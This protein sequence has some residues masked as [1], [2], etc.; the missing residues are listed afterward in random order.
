ME[1]FYQKIQG[2]SDGIDLLYRQVVAAVPKPQLRFNGETFAPLTT[3]QYHFVEV[4]SWRGRSSAFMAVE[5]INSG[6]DIRFD[7][8]DTWQGTSNETAHTED[9]AVIQG[10][11]YEEFI[12]AMK[13]VE[14]HYH[15]V[16]MP[17]VAAADLYSDHSLDFVFI[18]ADHSYEACRSDIIAWLPKVRPGGILAGHDYN[19][20]PDPQTGLDYGVGKAVRELLPNHQSIPWCWLY[21]V[22]QQQ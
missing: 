3:R 2:W 21:Q 18:D 12:T 19:P 20:Q 16:R 17:S 7:C 6:L 8:V 13:P 22:P 1:H 9:P 5:I 15:A 11:L 4:G 10:T 14:G